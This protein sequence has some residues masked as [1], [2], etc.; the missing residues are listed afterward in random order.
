MIGFMFDIDM[1]GNVM[2]VI[3]V[4]WVVFVGWDIGIM[5][6]ICFVVLFEIVW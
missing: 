3:C 6:E 2:I 1:G 4:V 5:V